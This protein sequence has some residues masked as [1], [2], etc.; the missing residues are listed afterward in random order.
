MIDWENIVIVCATKD[1]I[2]QEFTQKAISHLYKL[3]GK[4]PKYFV[5]EV[6]SAGSFS[7]G[8]VDPKFRKV[9]FHEDLA[10]APLEGKSVYIFGIPCYEQKENVPPGE[11]SFRIGATAMAAYDN[12]A[13]EVNLV[14]TNSYFSRGDKAYFDYPEGSDERKRNKGRGRPALLQAKHFHIDGIKKIIT[15]ELHSKE[16]ENFYREV[17]G[18][19]NVLHSISASPH[20]AHYIAI[21]S[22]L[23]RTNNGEQIVIVSPDKGA[24]ARTDEFVNTLKHAYGLTNISVLYLDKTRKFANNPDQVEIII[25][26]VKP[27][28]DN[29]TT[30]NNKDII[31]WD[32]LVDTAGTI[33]TVAKTLRKEGVNGDAHYGIPASVSA[34]LVHPV[35]AGSNYETAMQKLMSAELKELVL[36]NTHPYI[37]DNLL[38]P[39]KEIT[40][41]IRTA[42]MFGEAIFNLEQNKSVNSMYLKDGNIS[43]EIVAK[44]FNMKRSSSFKKKR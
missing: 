31:I 36:F 39:L 25:N 38:Y 15:M 2:S 43:A 23:S 4:T 40:S 22:T 28:S 26:K 32:D 29:F 19:N 37:E 33:S 9:L 13:K 27:C 3:V 10:K 6:F 44:T 12:G 5:S 8:E 34:I 30:L 7:A 41:V 11:L 18:H 17:Y 42:W 14:L 1:R 35:L 21:E 20:A 24:R 16:V